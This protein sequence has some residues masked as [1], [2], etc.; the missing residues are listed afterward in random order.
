MQM[1]TSDLASL[2]LKPYENATRECTAG[3]SSLK[4]IIYIAKTLQ[5]KT[6]SFIL[7]VFVILST[8]HT[9]LNWFKSMKAL[10]EYLWPIS[11][12]LSLYLFALT[13]IPD[14]KKISLFPMAVFLNYSD[15]YCHKFLSTHSWMVRRKKL[16]GLILQKW[17]LQKTKHLVDWQW[18]AVLRWSDWSRQLKCHAWEEC[19]NTKSIPF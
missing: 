8:L 4:Q 18:Q 14:W 10:P 3:S 7:L 5:R 1:P 19:E 11:V 15:S 2:L 12:W 17:L 16:Q 6:R 13:I 9:I